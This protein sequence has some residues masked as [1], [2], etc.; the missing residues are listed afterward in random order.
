[1]NKN[2][3]KLSILERMGR[4]WHIKVPHA[5]MTKENTQVNF[6]QALRAALTESALWWKQQ[7]NPR[8]RTTFLSSN[9][10]MIILAHRHIQTDRPVLRSPHGSLKKAIALTFT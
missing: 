2:K 9:Q 7:N 4:L 6:S 5:G 1:M 3:I 10:Y 8:K